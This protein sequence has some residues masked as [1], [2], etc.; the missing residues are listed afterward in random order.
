MSKRDVQ[1]ELIE[2][3][4]SKIQR[5]IIRDATCGPFYAIIAHGTTGATGEKQ[6][7]ID[8]ALSVYENYIGIYNAPDGRA[9]T[10]YMAFQRFDFPHWPSFPQHSWPVI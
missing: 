5:E 10:L 6:F 2:I 1:N 9:D 3:M 8:R 4:A 7:A